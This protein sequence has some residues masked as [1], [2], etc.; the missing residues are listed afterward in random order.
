MSFTVMKRTKEAQYVGW[1]C[2]F[3][4]T[5]QDRLTNC[6]GK[7]YWALLCY[8][9]SSLLLLNEEFNL[10]KSPLLVR[11]P[12]TVLGGCPS[13]GGFGGLAGERPA[14]GPLGFRG[15]NSAWGALLG[16]PLPATATLFNEVGER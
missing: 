7:A 1:L 3:I 16:P 11:R 6:F 10:V 9:N 8:T 5:Q 14:G 4:D 13:E 15:V 12:I 2:S